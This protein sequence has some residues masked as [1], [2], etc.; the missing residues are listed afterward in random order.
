MALRM[1]RPLIRVEAASRLYESPPADGSV[2]PLY[3]NAAARITTGLAPELL[4][5]HLQRVEQW[6]GR[7]RAPMWAPRPIDIDIAL[8]DD[9]VLQSD[10]L[11]I[12]H[13][14]LTERAFVVRP[15][16]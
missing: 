16:L 13:P 12:P 7:R 5:A 9:T 6:I 10:E 15:L 11:T 8:Y 4:L 3:Y 2:Q 1:M 14:R